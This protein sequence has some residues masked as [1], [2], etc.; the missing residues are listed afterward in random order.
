MSPRSDQ[1]RLR[2]RDAVVALCREQAFYLKQLRIEGTLCVVSDQSSVLITQISEQIGDMVKQEN[3][4]TDNLPQLDPEQRGG[5]LEHQQQ[6][7]VWL[8]N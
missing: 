1:L 5:N 3:N 2:L 6:F 8:L 4:D 7:Q